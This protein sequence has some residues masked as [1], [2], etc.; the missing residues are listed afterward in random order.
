MENQNN[1]QEPVSEDVHSTTPS[2]ETGVSDFRESMENRGQ[3]RVADA[4]G[5]RSMDGEPHTAPSNSL[6]DMPTADDPFGTATP[7][8][9]VAEMQQTSDGPS[10]EQGQGTEDP[11]T[12]GSTDPHNFMTHANSGDETELTDKE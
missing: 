5:V 2:G 12:G 4:A 3:G 10:Y 1:I 6:N 8:A 11:A 7:S 9:R